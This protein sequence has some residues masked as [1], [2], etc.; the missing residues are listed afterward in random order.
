MILQTHVWVTVISPLCIIC[1]HFIPTPFIGWRHQNLRFFWL[2]PCCSFPSTWTCS[3]S[4]TAVPS[5]MATSKR[6][7]LEWVSVSICRGSSKSDSPSAS[8]ILPRFQL[9]SDHLKSN[10][11]STN[12]CCK[13]LRPSSTQLYPQASMKVRTSS[14]IGGKSQSQSHPL[15]RTKMTDHIYTARSPAEYWAFWRWSHTLQWIC[16][17]DI[18]W[19]RGNPPPWRWKLQGFLW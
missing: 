18:C 15:V 17:K 10:F 12:R 9:L 3:L 13:M 6:E 2:Q 11:M 19:C 5:L 7:K 4:I 14:R 1:F 16:S 8:R